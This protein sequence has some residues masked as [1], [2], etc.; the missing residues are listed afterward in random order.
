MSILLRFAAGLLVLIPLTRHA[1]GL[2]YQGDTWILLG[3]SNGIIN[4][5][6]QGRWNNWGGPLPLLQSIP[7][8]IM[9]GL[10]W[11]DDRRVLHGLGVL[12][13]V[14]FALL[15]LWSWRSL[16]EKS[17][18]LAWFF[19]AVLISGP[20]LKYSN[21]TFGEM[22]AAAVTLGF[23]VA[24]RDRAPGWKIFIFFILAALSKDTAVPFL[25]LLGL[26]CA[27]EFS[28]DAGQRRF[29]FRRW[30]LLLA[31]AACG[32]TV[33]LLFNYLKFGSIFN[34]AYL[35]D[36]SVVHSLRIQLN[37][38]FAIWFAPN[39]GVMFFWPSCFLL[40]VLS[41]LAQFAPGKTWRDAIPF[42]L[43]MTVLAG[44]TAGFS[45]WYAPLGWVCWGPRLILPWLPAVGYA[46]VTAYPV[47]IEK[48]IRAVLGSGRRFQLTCAAFIFL[49]FPHFAVL[50]Q[51]EIMNRFFFEPDKA[52][53]RMA[54]V[55][56]DP[57]YYY[58]ATRQALWVR[59]PM[60]WDAFRELPN[61][62]TLTFSLGAAV[63][64]VGL[65]RRS[66]ER[67]S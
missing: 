49:A 21:S 22:L 43:I 2:V 19:V 5:V 18:R 9:K 65:L 36:I 57:I 48:K 41:G 3:Q 31:A 13:L 29:L 54:Y 4:A 67:Y 42:L 52:F 61:A 59:R 53:P 28:S 60:L 33:V 40:L 62:W 15:L 20:L 11:A 27:G 23:V 7:V 17:T 37:F 44:L 45:K 50:F 34:K 32:A 1:R 58:N 30:R 12:S 10:G 6:A 51:P 16:F 24:C 14:S 46:L 38:F 35:D 64:L 39:G 66:K 55:W 47:E 26:A 63:I 25:L 56:D 8:F